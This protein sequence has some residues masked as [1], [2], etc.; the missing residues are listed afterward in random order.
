MVSLFSGLT[1][2]LIVYSIFLS[3]SC[4]YKSLGRFCGSQPPSDI[5]SPDQCMR[6][7]FRSS[8]GKANSRGFRARLI[9]TAEIKTLLPDH[10][11]RS[12][13]ARATYIINH[14][15]FS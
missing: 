7:E 1:E 4:S 5:I 14:H 13:K 3:S 8:S 15:V 11:F 2:Y 10:A 6:L 12:E 9:V